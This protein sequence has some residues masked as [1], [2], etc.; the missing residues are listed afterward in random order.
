L[1]EPVKISYNIENMVAYGDYSFTL[2]AFD[3]EG[4]KTLRRDYADKY[5][6]NDPY[7]PAQKGKKVRQINFG[8]CRFMFD[9]YLFK[10]RGFFNFEKLIDEFRDGPENFLQSSLLS[11]DNIRRS[12]DLILGGSQLSTEKLIVLERNFKRIDARAIRQRIGSKDGKSYW[13]YNYPMHMQTL[14][15]NFLYLDNP[16]VRKDK[17]SV[18]DVTFNCHC[19]AVRDVL[20]NFNILKIENSHVSKIIPGKISIIFKEGDNVKIT[21]TDCIGLCD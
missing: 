15:E 6:Y 5:E 4:N 9:E 17:Y 16:R 1:D 20:D 11:L 14:Y 7:S 18:T 13:R 21:V 2:D 19:D 10:K 12:S 3:V 8:A